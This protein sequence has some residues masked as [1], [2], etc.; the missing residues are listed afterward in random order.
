VT[1]GSNLLTGGDF[2]PEASWSA[3]VAGV[4]V[5]A[6]FLMLAHRRGHLVSPRRPGRVGRNDA[7]T[8]IAS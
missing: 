3:V 1:S 2:G 5:T 8:T 7:A 4:L 6:A